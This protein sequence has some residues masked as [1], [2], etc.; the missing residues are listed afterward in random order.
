MRRGGQTGW[1]TAHQGP[2]VVLAVLRGMGSARAGS[3]N[4]LLGCVLSVLECSVLEKRGDAARVSLHVVPITAAGLQVKETLVYKIM[5]A[6]E[7][8]KL[9]S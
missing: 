5:Q 9:V 8:D 2:A 7:V 4:F 3:V 1:K 6:R